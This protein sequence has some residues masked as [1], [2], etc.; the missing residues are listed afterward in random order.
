MWYIFPQIQGIGQSEISKFYSLN[1]IV[2]AR[3]YLANPILC[4][5]LIEISTLLLQLNQ[6]DIYEILGYPDNLKLKSCMT[7]FSLASNGEILIFNEIL[8]KYFGNEKCNK[9]I[10][11]IDTNAHI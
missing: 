8:K 7:L 1:T 2:E 10:L 9:T 4:N 11:L 6:N 5:R 3:D